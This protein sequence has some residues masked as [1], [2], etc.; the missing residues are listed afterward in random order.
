MSQSQWTVNVVSD[1]DNPG[2]LLLNLG[3][4]ICEQL[5]WK[6]GDTIIWHEQEDGTWLLT[7]QSTTSTG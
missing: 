4:E 6:I 5:G 3:T 2:E 1:P 7:P